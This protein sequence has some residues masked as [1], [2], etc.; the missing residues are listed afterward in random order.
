MPFTISAALELEVFSRVSFD[1][2]A[3]HENLG[4]PIRWVHP[5][6]LHDIARFLAGGE[7][8]LTAGLGIGH[9]EE[10]QRAYARSV[11]DAGA[12]VLVLELS[13]REY[14]RMPVA[15]IDESACLGLPLVG[16]EG[17]LPFVEVSAQVHEQLV[18]ERFQELTAH[19]RLNGRV[20]ELLAA[21]GDYLGLCHV[22]AQEIKRPVVLEDL[23]REPVAHTSESVDS[24]AAVSNWSQHSRIHSQDFLPLST[25][26][27]TRKVDSAT[28]LA[29]CTRKPVTIRG[30]TWGWLHVLHEPGGLSRADIHACERTADAI[31]ISVMSAR[32]I[33]ARVAQRESAL[34][35]RLLLG[36]ISGDAFIS[37][38]LRLGK[39]LRSL[40]LVAVWAS[41]ASSDD[42]SHHH[43]A[44][45]AESLGF[46]RVIADID[47]HAMAV[48]GLPGGADLAQLIEWLEIHGPTTGISRICEPP[49]LEAAIRQARHAA[50]AAVALPT[51]KPVQF[52]DLGM[53]R[54]LVS[55]SDG[56]ELADYVEDEL[57]AILAHD[58][59]SP[60]PLLPTLEAYLENGAN[61][62]Q[63]ATA[64]YIQRRTLYYRLERLNALVRGPLDDADVRRDLSFALHG[65][66][67][68]NRLDG[69]TRP[70]VSRDVTRSRRD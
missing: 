46:P 30:E 23:T 48:V 3:G 4:R 26:R 69:A 18:N 16:L 56:P 2:Y 25:A 43:L 36:D 66:K 15:L 62:S 47:E 63:T 31:A 19:E 42:Q 9:T 50:A 11:S 27:P 6:E 65:F 64:L 57:G 52:D 5:V 22:L 10:A 20:I 67:V 41:A 28:G 37:R 7:M 24:D 40:P 21:G 45:A 60:N 38:A 61:K 70:R 44:H 35:S 53:I 54:L 58:A 33:G 29:E 13:G 12:A 68:L 49:Q 32:E 34:V 14:S 17:E 8:L 59:A 1:V 39:D 55:L 51:S